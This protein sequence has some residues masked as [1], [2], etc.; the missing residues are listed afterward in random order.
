[1]KRKYLEY[2]VLAVC[3][4][5]LA[6]I[7]LMPEPEPLPP[8]PESQPL[9]S[10]E[11]QFKRDVKAMPV[12]ETVTAEV[13]EE[14]TPKD[15]IPL[16]DCDQVSLYYICKVNKVPM[17]YALAIIETESNFDYYAVGSRGEVGLFQIHPINW[18]RMKAQD[19]DVKCTTG[20]IEAGVMILKESLD[21]AQ[22]LD[23]ATMI[24]KCGE[25][26]A[27][28]LIS[29]GVKLKT[30]ETVALLTMKYEAILNEN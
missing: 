30:C 28:E 3:I 21:R 20:N 13:E 18:E 16:E 29:E 6:I 8:I 24:Y 4:A 15:D 9:G 14:F 2:L 25:S 5:V 26:R 17:A 19:I 12:I 10:V 22:E 7:Y 11:Q 27:T 23:Y 1:M